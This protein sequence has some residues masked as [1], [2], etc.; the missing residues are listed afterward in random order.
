MKKSKQKKKP[1]IYAFINGR[2][3]KNDFV[4]VA[5]AE[6]GTVLA[7]HV[8]SSRQWAKHDI[9]VTSN[10]KHEVYNQF[11]MNG[12]DIEWITREE[13]PTHEGFQRALEQHHE[14]YGEDSDKKPW[15]DRVVEE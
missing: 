12:W 1:K 10:W 3:G 8:S 7:N 11:Y 13:A 15:Q 2:F 9:G 6:E 5:M 4:V 14:R